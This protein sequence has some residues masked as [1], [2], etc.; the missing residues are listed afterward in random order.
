M[1]KTSRDGRLTAL[2]AL[3]A[4]ENGD[5]FKILIGTILSQR[6]RDESTTKASE[7]LFAVYGTPQKLAAADPGSVRELIR[8]VLYY[9]VKSKN[10]I[11]V[12][13]QIV[14][15]YGGEVPRD[16]DSLLKLPSVG[17]KTA[18]C[19]L[20][21]GFNIPAIPVDTH[22]HRISNR[23]GLVQTKTP[24][25]TEVELERIVPRRYWLELNELFV[26]FGQTTCLPRGP[27]CEI[28]TLKSS[29]RY[30]KEVVQKKDE[31]GEGSSS[32]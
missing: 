5:P 9:D 21:Y 14:T 17:R 2:A 24:E 8:N 18:N 10:I 6:T 31:G 28:C 20:V 3:R 1:L 16:M 30:Y 11:K 15:E 7:R 26:R 25:E 22:V 32:T 12:A 23:L 29:C 19:V 4:S 13:K 27:R